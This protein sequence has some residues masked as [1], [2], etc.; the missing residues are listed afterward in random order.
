MK[1]LKLRLIG[2]FFFMI[3]L[4]FESGCTDVKD[5]EKMN[6]VSAIG[7]DFKEGKYHSYLQFVDYVSSAKTIESQNMPSKVWVG[8]GIGISLEESLFDLYR[9]SQEKIYWGHMTAILISEDA[10]KKGIG[11][12]YDSFVRYSE[13]RLTPWV[14]AT[15]ES[16]KDIFSTIGFY[17]QSPLST[18]LHEPDGIYS[19][20]SLIKSIKLHRLINQ[21]NEPGYTSCIPVLV[22]NK[23][24]WVE[25]EKPESKLMIDGALFLKND[26]FR[27]YIPLAK[28]SGL[29]WVQPGSIRAAIPVPNNQE[30][31]V[32]VVVN[33][34]KTKLTLVNQGNNPQF[35]IKMKATGYIVNRSKND[36]LGLQQLTEE[37]KVA[38]QQEIRELIQNG[39][40]KKTDVLNLE[41]HLYH[42]HYRKWQAMSSAED[43]LLTENVIHNIKIDFELIHSSSEK[44]T[45]FKRSK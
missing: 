1:S 14:Y 15:R 44:N 33:N 11:N 40:K 34:P 41:Y 7:V 27:S 24:Q 5:I 36:L 19:Q 43:K 28:L 35:D 13:F 18:I 16:I 4:L 30:P 2:V 17:G 38:I 22:I 6:Y 20:T 29:R 10:F 39:L 32:Q 23:K 25:K 21:I 31:T 9:T 3:G 45:R 42:D 37:T 8:E 26:V 12:I